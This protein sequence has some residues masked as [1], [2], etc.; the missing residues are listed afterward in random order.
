MVGGKRKLKIEPSTRRCSRVHEKKGHWAHHWCPL[1]LLYIN[2][3]VR[4]LHRERSRA[5][6]SSDL[7]CSTLRP[8][9]QS[10][11]TSGC[12][13][14]NRSSPVFMTNMM[15]APERAPQPSI[16]YRRSTTVIMIWAGDTAKKQNRGLKKED[17]R[18]EL[19]G[20]AYTSKQGGYHTAFSSYL[21]RPRS[22]VLC[23]T[24]PSCG[25]ILVNP[26]ACTMFL[27]LL[28]FAVY[29]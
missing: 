7:T 26:F 18:R 17:R 2:Q 23:K 9:L 13:I 5:L 6:S 19:I 11:S 25:T 1:S 14:S 12:W 3:T 15:K 22:M 20:A 8:L 21:W 28:L 24:P 29:V 10:T 16:L 27:G 4:P